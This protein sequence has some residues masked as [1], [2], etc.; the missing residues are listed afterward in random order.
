[1]K[2]KCQISKTAIDLI[3]QFEGYRRESVQLPDGRWM[4][5]YGHT[6]SARAGAV[7]SEADAEALLLYDLIRVSEAIGPA[8][9]SPLGQNQFDALVCFA[10]NI[11]ADA[12][13]SSQVLKLVN[14]GAMLQAAYAI[15]AWRKSDAGGGDSVI[16]GL[17]RR[18]AAE[19]AMFLTPDSGFRPAPTA[20]V[21]PRLDTNAVFA[22]P[23]TLAPSLI[24]KVAASPPPPVSDASDLDEVAPVN[25]PAPEFTVAA[26][27]E[28]LFAIPGY[29]ADARAKTARSPR[30]LSTLQMAMIGLVGLAFL[31]AAVFLGFRGV[32]SPDGG[33]AQ[34]VAAAVTG[35]IG[36]DS[37]YSEIYTI[38]NRVDEVTEPGKTA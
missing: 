5:G 21:R 31:A 37:L 9:F 32:A 30:K 34:L 24:S 16:D 27:G 17:V 25:E 28:M 18:R 35:A 19:K 12:F 15:E 29:D 38:L 11:G 1:M 20:I 2:Q 22:D 4:I 14:A 13:K 23:A 6:A 8:V 36:V 26:T 10:F 3:K 33:R 7:V